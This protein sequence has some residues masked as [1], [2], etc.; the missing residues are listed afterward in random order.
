[1]SS[2]PVQVVTR[3]RPMNTKEVAGK[4]L[5]IVDVKT[6]QNQIRIT[7]K[8]GESKAFTF[9]YVYDASTTQRFFY[10]NSCSPLI[11]SVLE[12]FNATIFAYGQTGCGKS[13]SMQGCNN[14]KELR[15]VIPNAFEHIFDEINAADDRE[16]LVRCS[17]L[18]IY[19]ENIRDLLSNNEKKLEV[20]EDPKKGVFVQNLTTIVVEDEITLN[21]IVE[22]GLKNR[23]VAATQMNSESSRSHAIFTIVVEVSETDTSTGREIFRA[24]KLNLVDLAGSERQKKTGASG[25]RLKE[26]SKINLSL[27]AL[28]NVISSLSDGKGKHVPYRDSK[29]TRLLQDSLG[30]NTK[31]LMIAACSPA[32]Y[33]YEETLS[34]LRY[35]K[36][37]KSIENKPVI[38]EDPK[39]ALLREYKDEIKLLKRQLD[40]NKVPEQ[41]T[42][43]PQTIQKLAAINHGDEIPKVR[44]KLPV[45]VIREVERVEV[46]VEKVISVP[47]SRAYAEKGAMES[48]NQAIVKQRDQMGAELAKQKSERDMLEAKIAQLSKCIK[49][50]L[51]SSGSVRRKRRKKRKENTSMENCTNEQNRQDKVMHHDD[52]VTEEHETKVNIEKQLKEAMTEIE[53]LKDEFSTTRSNMLETIREQGKEINLWSQIAKQ[54]LAPD[55][56][57]ELLNNAKWD[58]QRQEW[59]IQTSAQFT[60]KKESQIKFPALQTGL[61]RS[62]TEML[63]RPGHSHGRKSLDKTRNDDRLVPISNTTL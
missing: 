1:M 10:D 37:A 4:C 3:V 5:P 12:G 61:N 44:E 32:D 56:I 43:V 22:K 23:S 18:E 50:N 62:S 17:Y 48:Y 13:F 7:N 36:R 46:I 42:E 52:G 33:N 54:S 53:D 45:E 30:G 34:T 41:T 11:D 14:P 59:R 21:N 40:E 2:C 51:A 35:A 38:N 15:G 9:D 27:S 19:N 25:D 6:S 8:K 39:D 16:F 47:N 31:T 55:R 58:T 49:T 29:L 60:V 57:A 20:K 28:G 26:G 63:R 24:G